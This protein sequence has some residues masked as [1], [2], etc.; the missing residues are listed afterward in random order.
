MKVKCIHAMVSSVWNRSKTLIIGADVGTD[1][2]DCSSLFKE[3]ELD[4]FIAND[5]KTINIH[6]IHHNFEHDIVVIYYRDIPEKTIPPSVN[7]RFND[8]DVT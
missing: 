2:E 3:R 8:M 6:S 5:G 1:R 7:G 4:E